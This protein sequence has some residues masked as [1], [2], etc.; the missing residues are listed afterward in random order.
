MVLASASFFV[1][2]QKPPPYD[3]N[4]MA[5]GHLLVLRVV[6]GDK[7]L[8]LFFAGKKAGELDL[9]KDHVVL[10][11]TAMG[12][13][14]QETLRF[15]ENGEAYDVLDLPAWNEPYDLSVKSRVR[16]KV[17]ELKVKMPAAKP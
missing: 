12:G 1:F 16:G 14:K 6:P 5:Q 15:K 10:S 4:Y 3:P 11:V 7:S 9:K 17:E 8:K 13:K 2:A